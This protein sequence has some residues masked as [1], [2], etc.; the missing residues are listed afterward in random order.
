M[1]HT[2]DSV[3]HCLNCY[4]TLTETTEFTV[5]LQHLLI[6]GPTLRDMLC[7]RCG[8]NLSKIRSAVSCDEC[9]NEYSQYCAWD[10]KRPA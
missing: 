4:E 8:A 7:Y 6:D 3:P 1:T 10:R 9:F 5:S 2:I